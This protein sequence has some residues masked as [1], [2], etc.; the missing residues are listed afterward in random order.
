MPEANFAEGCRAPSELSQT[1]SVGKTAQWPMVCEVYV[2][3]TVEACPAHS[4]CV[5]GDNR[6][7]WVT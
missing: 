3:G 2:M 4:T 7:E 5:A 1:R 6:H